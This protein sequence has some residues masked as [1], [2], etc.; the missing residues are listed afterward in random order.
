MLSRQFPFIQ[1]GRTAQVLVAVWVLIALFITYLI[2]GLV[3]SRQS[4]EQRVRDQ[5]MS[6]ARLVDE[7]ASATFGRA[8]ITLMAIMDHISASDLAGAKALSASRRKEIEALMRSQQQRTPGFLAM[9]LANAQGVVIA[10][11]RGAPPGLSISD[12]EHFQI[13]QR[14]PRD[15][16]VISQAI[17]GRVSKKWGVMLARRISLTDGSFGGMIGVNLGLD[18]NFTNFYATL[19]LG[20]NGAV[21]LRDSEDRL[22]VRYPVVEQKLGKPVATSGPI[23]ERLLA[24]DAE[25]VL[26]IPSAIDNIE[27]IFAFRR[28]KD[29][30]IYAAVGLSLDEALVSW[31]R[32]RDM[33]AVGALLVILAGI[34]ITFA[35]RRMER[36]DNQLKTHA[37]IVE[38]SEDAIATADLNG[39]ITSWNSG[40]QKVYGYSAEEVIGKHV[41]VITPPEKGGEYTLLLENIRSGKS[42]SNLETVRVRK[43]GQRIDV[44]LT[45]SPISERGG[46][47]VSYSAIAR[48]I[49]ESKRLETKIF[50]FNHDLEQLVLQRT[51]QLRALS[52]ELTM[53]EE[54]ER[55]AIAQDLHDDLGQILAIVKL[56]LTALEIPEKSG[57]Q[58]D[59]QQ[60]V[61]EIE[62]LIDQAN[63]S[64]R[65]L[66][67]QLSPPVLHQFGLVPALEW[68]AEEMHRSYGLSVRISDDGEPKPF[69][70]ASSSMLFRA[71]RELLVNVHKH[72]KV[73]SADV[74]ISVAEGRLIL[75][76]T[77]SGI[78]FDAQKP[79]APSA[80]I[81][82]GLFSVRERIIHGGGE[83]HIDSTPGDGTVVVLILPLARRSKMRL[84]NSDT[85]IVGR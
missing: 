36:I 38:S 83:I 56:K 43:D 25:G 29:Y 71:V 22:L 72:A 68:L 47:I 74:D 57:R 31:R 49:T 17:L 70:P 63:R 52:K 13:L 9:P 30:P 48:D 65:S 2:S 50:R 4:V 6:Y 20:K 66:S 42:V 39:I 75:S 11:P 40:S 26:T 23:K 46:R 3:S 67:L 14:S 53:V 41:S 85:T 33:V 79:M 35:L 27:R 5:A 19:S 55:Q 7:H 78:G 73:G 84:E 24:G 59:L 10:E 15:T 80:E 44:S 45:L 60:Q 64:V 1:M 77:D 18:E 76:I 81:G 34:S 69:D 82:F 21:S 32:D 58:G 51:A 28:M 62:T 8:N 12:R 37:V 54:R 61:K 16:P